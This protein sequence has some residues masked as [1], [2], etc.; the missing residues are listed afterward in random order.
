MLALPSRNKKIGRILSR[1]IAVE[2]G[3]DLLARVAT[4]GK[5]E[6]QALCRRR[7]NSIDGDDNVRAECAEFF[8]YLLAVRP[9]WE[10]DIVVAGLNFD[11]VCSGRRH[12]IAYGQRAGVDGEDEFLRVF[13]HVILF[14]LD[15]EA[16]RR[17]HACPRR[18]RRHKV[19]RKARAGA[20]DES[21]SAVP[22]IVSVRS[23]F[24]NQINIKSAAIDCKVG[25]EI[26]SD[27]VALL[28]NGRPLIGETDGLQH[29]IILNR[30]GI[31]VVATANRA[32]RSREAP[33]RLL[34]QFEDDLVVI[35]ITIVLVDVNGDFRVKCAC[36]G[37]S[38]IEGANNLAGGREGN[39]AAV[40]AGDDCESDRK[41]ARRHRIGKR[42]GDVESG[43]FVF[44]DSAAIFAPE[45]CDVVV[46]GD[47]DR[48]DATPGGLAHLPVEG[49]VADRR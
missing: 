21:L 41:S 11:G 4:N 23:A 15:L 35:E 46:G 42:D 1:S 25:V 34:C 36:F 17:R 19:D 37:D 26:D 9:R 40:V 45:V 22:A 28:R 48:V 43:V 30:E 29:V 2:G 32:P 7:R 39:N 27:N 38:D 16:R 12:A 49:Q 10:E 44:D 6:R 47:G 13:G 31:S 33:I 20:A 5:N 14:D 24:D 18:R 8:G 3:D